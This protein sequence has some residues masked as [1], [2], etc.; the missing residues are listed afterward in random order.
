MRLNHVGLIALGIVVALMLTAFAPAVRADEGEAFVTT[1]KPDY[2]PEEIVTIFGYHFLAD[3]SVNV[4]VTRPDGN[5]SGW[6]ATSTGNG[7]FET[8]YQLNGIF[9]MYLVEATDGTHYANTTFTD[10]PSQ[11]DLDQCR[12][13]P[14]GSPDDCKDLGGGDGWVNGNAGASQA[15]Y[16]EGYSIP[17]RAVMTDIPTGTSITVV[18]GYDIKHSGKHALDFLT[19]LYGESRPDAEPALFTNGEAARFVRF[20]N[21]AEQAVTVHVKR[22]AGL[23]QGARSL[24]VARRV[25]TTVSRSSVFPGCGAFPKRM[26]RAGSTP[27]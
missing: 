27:L 19:A 4:S 22:C 25:R 1:D 26:N 6:D 24:M 21:N 2:H 11:I 12:N 18:L 23:R 13:G 16:V 15:H 7:S 5:Q 8:T 14:A 17:Y 20:G 9:G 10:A 3:W